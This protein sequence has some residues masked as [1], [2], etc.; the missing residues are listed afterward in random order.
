MCSRHEPN[1]DSACFNGTMPISAHMQNGRQVILELDLF[2]L[3]N[4]HGEE[5]ESHKKAAARFVT[6]CGLQE[7]L[8]KSLAPVPR[9]VCKV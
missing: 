5:H 2:D 4:T 6:K 1:S 3:V 9:I 7:L 8:R